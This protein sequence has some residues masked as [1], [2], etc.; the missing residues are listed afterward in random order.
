MR[1]PA[2]IRAIGAIGSQAEGE[3][4][5][6]GAAGP[7]MPSLQISDA[8]GLAY[9]DF[10]AAVKGALRDY[11]RPDLLARNPL[12]RGETEKPGA[13]A[14]PPQ[15]QALLSEAV[16]AVLDNPRDE[17]LRHVIELTYFQPPLKQEAVAERLSLS[18]GTYRRY[19]TS[20]RPVDTLAVGRPGCPAAPTGPGFRDA[21]CGDR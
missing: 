4:A 8:G 12:V 7:G 6:G 14:G 11:H 16:K 17:K 20:A 19:L 15:L 3:P 10:A 2:R 21:H 5:A 18:F 9:A 1:T 13:S